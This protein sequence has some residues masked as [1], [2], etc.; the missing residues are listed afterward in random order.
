MGSDWRG[1]FDNLN[2]ICKV[3]YFE[4]TPSISTTQ[5]IDVIKKY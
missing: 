4:R 5:I 1:K 3:D 2:D